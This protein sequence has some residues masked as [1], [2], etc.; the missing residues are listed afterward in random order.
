VS[1]G[2]VLSASLPPP[3]TDGS[4]TTLE[5]TYFDLDKETRAIVRK[6]AVRAYLKR[7][8][9]WF[10]G[11]MEARGIGQEQEAE[12]TAFVVEL[13]TSCFTII[14]MNLA[15]AVGSKRKAFVFTDEEDALCGCGEKK[16]HIC[17]TCEGYSKVLNLNGP[18]APDCR[19]R[20]RTLASRPRI[21]R[22]CPP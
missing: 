1:A 8:P 6:S 14:W 13:L 20:K 9:P 22:T 21:K 2:V 19:S 4:N 7:N 5:M 15:S 16:V 18:A 3:R 10:K 17:T 12:G 11:W